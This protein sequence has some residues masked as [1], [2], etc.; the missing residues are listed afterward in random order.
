VEGMEQLP[1]WAEIQQTGISVWEWLLTNV[2]VLGNAVQLGLVLV[3]LI[4]G[5]L[6]RERF[7]RWVRQAANSRVF[8]KTLSDY[9]WA[10][11][12]IDG[13]ETIA[14]P[15]F[16]FLSLWIMTLV[17]SS[18]QLRHHLMQSVVGLITAWIV[19]RL[20][21]TVIRNPAWARALALIAWTVAALNLVGLLGPLSLFLDG[22]ALELGETRISVLGLLKGA[23]ALAFLLWAAGFISQ[24]IENRLKDVDA[25]TPSVRVLFGKLTRIILFTLALLMALNSVG[26]DLTALAV[27]SGAVGLGV[28]FGLQ[29][30]VSNLISGVI[31]L[32]DKSVK[33]GDVIALGQ[34]FGWIN[35]LS[36]RYVSVITRDGTEHLIPNEELISQRVENWSFTDSKIRLP[37]MIG[38]AYETDVPK[39]MELCVEAAKVEDR[40]LK[41]PEPVC[42]LVGFG[43]SAIDLELR[44]WIEDP[45]NGMAN[46]RSNIYL[47]IWELFKEHDVQF[48][49]PQQDIHI[50]EIVPIRMETAKEG[51]ET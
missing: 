34:S 7:S 31:L 47:R 46:V 49:F 44:I 12:L 26:I 24:L 15:A 38:V 35:K 20:A 13:L 50:K 29:K 6:V 48:P 3:V 41:T 19:I 25:L 17:A 23:A 11:A 42:R 21:S 33:P 14:V 32:L 16:W 43:D 5:R 9:G 22:L 36:A 8:E 30:V 18:L 37:M 28:G 1:Y 40:V 10:K 45:Q 4:A 27:F 2:F 39:A 51:K